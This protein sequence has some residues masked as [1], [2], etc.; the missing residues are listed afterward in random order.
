MATPK[1][2]TTNIIS[3]S[4]GQ[5]LTSVISGTN[6]LSVSSTKPFT[7]QPGYLLLNDTKDNFALISYANIKNDTFN[8]LAQMAGKGTTILKGNMT[9]NVAAQGKTLKGSSASFT[10]T[11]F[12]IEKGPTFIG[13][14]YICILGAGGNGI[15]S[16]DKTTSTLP[17]ATQQ[18]V[19]KDCVLVEA[20][21]VTPGQDP[22]TITV[23]AETIVIESSVPTEGAT[24]TSET[25]TVK[26]NTSFTLKAV[27]TTV[28]FAKATASKPG[29]LLMP[30]SNGSIEVVSYTGLT[31][32][33][34]TGA[35]C[36]KAGTF[37]IGTAV[38]S[39]ANS[40]IT[41]SF[42]NNT[43][44]TDEIYVAIAGERYDASGNLTNGYLTQPTAGQ[45]LTYTE[46]TTEKKVPTFKL[47]KANSALSSKT[48]LIIPNSP[49]GRFTAC[50]IIFSIGTP[51]VIDILSGAPAFPAC[52]NANDPNDKTIYDFVEFT[53]RNA[54]NDGVLF[55][56]TTQVD[57]VGIPFK[58]QTVPADAINTD[59]VGITTSYATLKTDYA[60]YINTQ[61]PTATST[62]ANTAFNALAMNTRILNPADAITNPPGG[63]TLPALDSFFDTALTTFFNKYTT[64]KKTFILKRNGFYFSGKT[65][66]G[67]AP[68]PYAYNGTC[69]GTSIIIP[70]TT[71]TCLQAGM[72]VTGTG[73]TAATTISK[74]KVDSTGTTVTLNPATTAQGNP[75]DYTF[76]VPD[77]YTVLQLTQIT[78]AT[79]TTPVSGGQVYQIYAPYFGAGNYPTGFPIKSTTSTTKP[80]A[81]PWIAQASAGRMVFGNLGAFADGTFQAYAK[82]FTG[83]DASA[84]ILLD[85]ENTIVSA[86]NRGIA[87][88]VAAGSDVSAA[89]DDN[90]TFYPV[91]NTGSNWSNFYAGFLHNAGVSITAPGSSIGLA[92]GFAYDDQGNNDPT[93]AS[94]YP[95][96]VNIT[97]HKR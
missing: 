77:N 25:I 63:T 80:S 44:S 73:I 43:T 64:G 15:F 60:T 88:A 79:N 24:I 61:I 81:P 91:A 39:T 31:S 71:K 93:L 92:Y 19:F 70:S 89:W 32:T 49:F 14:G 65:I 22:F 38:K 68:A 29:Y 97:L 40:P 62:K 48:N 58:M 72:Q 69:T 86:F 83:T 87:N 35:T 30:M 2:T 82:Q 74:V 59:G 47:F 53:Q 51:P 1:T 84:Q 85:I 94:I 34:F 56:N 9:V 46:I 55:I 6:G 42:T 7:N 5:S 10:T 18:G 8:V 23:P 26:A 27:S 28:G 41:F 20:F 17:T 16:Y 50:R 11:S 57:Q 21:G 33:A 78:S 54:P 52:S 76:A 4:V 67:Y 75:A 13:T 96:K 12:T 36:K 45:A 90:T 37:T 66:I 95:S 3:P